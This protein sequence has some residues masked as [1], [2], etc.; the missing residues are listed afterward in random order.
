VK[1][2]GDVYENGYDFNFADLKNLNVYRF[3]CSL[4][5]CSDCEP[6][7]RIDN[8]YIKNNEFCLLDFF[9]RDYYKV[10]K[11][12]KFLSIPKIVI[13]EP[14]RLVCFKTDYLNT[15]KEEKEQAFWFSI[16]VILCRDDITEMDY[17]DKT[18]NDG[19]KIKITY[20]LSFFKDYIIAKHKRK[21]PQI[22]LKLKE[23][24]NQNTFTNDFINFLKG[25]ES[26]IFNE[27]LEN[28][29]EENDENKIAVFGK[30]Q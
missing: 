17:Y 27:K 22:F 16:K 7:Y 29:K 10:D 2:D 24:K 26:K 6:F 20:F 12:E 9:Y 30:K 19:G 13:G 21:R 14:K 28:A 23:K 25:E 4:L 5:G 18:L 3:F 11:L 8:V 1:V 15:Y